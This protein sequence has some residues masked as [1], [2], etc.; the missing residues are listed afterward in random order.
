MG[1]ED[2]DA[3][4]PGEAA[5]LDEWLREGQS[6]DDLFNFP[7]FELDRAIEAVEE[8]AFDEPAFETDEDM[9]ATL[10]SIES[11]VD[12]GFEQRAGPSQ[13]LPQPA[14]PAART[15]AAPQQ[16]ARSV[17]RAGQPSA[18]VAP[19]IPA[20]ADFDLDED[21]FDFDE[22]ETGAS[23]NEYAQD[24]DAV[25]S[26]AD[27]ALAEVDNGAF[28]E[29]PDE[30]Q[31][32]PA[33]AS[34]REQPSPAPLPPPT[35]RQ[36]R[37]ALASEPAPQAR[38]RELTPASRLETALRQDHAQLLPESP[39]GATARSGALRDR[40]SQLPLVWI[41]GS[42]LAFNGL[43][44]VI[45]WSS[46]SGMR[47]LVLESLHKVA[48]A[49]PPATPPALGGAQLAQ[50]AGRTGPSVSSGSTGRPESS[51]RS[52]PTWDKGNLDAVPT[53]RRVPAKRYLEAGEWNIAAGAYAQA[54]NELY[55]LLAQVDAVDAAAR[56][57]AEARANF[58]IAES[59]RLE[60]QALETQ[61]DAR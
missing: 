2:F 9:L 20:A 15:Q 18:Q 27:L 58:L 39:P 49:S 41:V 52:G 24:L 45:F 29:L 48:A 40:L 14:P 61:E 22:F 26:D 60:A 28:D 37:Q 12:V 30:V 43:A 16:A 23:T 36:A 35:S 6:D 51:E 7:E 44:L 53:D 55:Q 1:L 25:F 13:S 34:R 3:A 5:E 32:Q 57:D 17:E 47:E 21:L 56:E 31:E 42:I 59:L 50:P 10:D 19:P 11:L 38:A 8:L 54:R 46:L 4:E 33:V